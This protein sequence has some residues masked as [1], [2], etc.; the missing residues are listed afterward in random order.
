[1]DPSNLI[2]LDNLSEQLPPWRP[3]CENHLHAVVDMG[4]NGI[5]FSISSLAPPKTRLLEPIYTTRAAVSLYDALDSTSSP[6]FSDATIE[7]VSSALARFRHLALKHGVPAANMIIL[8]TEAMRRAANA[9]QMLD[10]VAAATGGLRV[11]VLDPP[12]E[13]LL[14][15]VMG[16]R[17]GLIDVKGG[18]LFLDLGGGSVQITWVDTDGDRYHMDAAAAGESM[19][20][21][22][23][24]LIRIFEEEPDEVQEEHIGK[25]QHGIRQIYGN[26][27][28]K[29][30][31]LH[32]IKDAH[33]RGERGAIVNAYMCGGGFRGYGSMLM[34]ND[35]ISPYPFS[36]TNGYSVPCRFFR[37][38]AKMSRVNQEYDGKILGLS[39]RRR[40]QFPAIVA[41]VEAVIAAVPN[42]GRV[43]FCGGS[44][45]QGALMMKLPLHI[46]ESNPL[47]VL[48]PVSEAE[49]QPFEAALHLLE[50][51]LPAELVSPGMPS[52]FSLGLGPLLVR[53][54]WDRAGH[55]ADANCAFALHTSTVR[56]PECPG[57]THLA[58][59]LLGLGASARWGCRFCPADAQLFRGL[60]RVADSHHEDASFWAIYVGAASSIIA[61]LFPV[62]PQDAHHLL[63]ALR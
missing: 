17:S 59:A 19:P 60:R 11:R 47:D 15:A 44:N 35:A 34:H 12:V 2:T 61:S 52:I 10:A 50:A 41:V 24:R 30:P 36:S 57:L 39:K 7:T 25:L 53:D 13:T 22:A 9:A 14:G 54:I 21:G 20:Y 62:M 3:D 31:A 42:L 29:F 26:L 32:A 63:D 18:A 1:M 5:R 27:A 56:D 37:Q 51:A 4:S 58:R 16:S 38:T 23:A 49:R 8:A 6:S 55:G 45:R 46:R 48:F 43:T 33:E 28:A 40:R